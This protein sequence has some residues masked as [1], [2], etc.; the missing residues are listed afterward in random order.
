MSQ[1]DDGTGLPSGSLRQTLTDFAQ[2]LKSGVR[3]AF[4]RPLTRADFRFSADQLVLLAVL[5]LLL[6]L[7]VGVVSGGPD[8][9]IDWDAL[10]GSVFPLLLLLLAAYLVSKVY[11]RDAIAVE[12]PI[13][14]L[15]STPVFAA[16]FA[17]AWFLVLWVVVR[18]QRVSAPL[19]VQVAAAEAV[20]VLL[21]LAS[22]PAQDGDILDN[23]VLSFSV[24]GI[25]EEAVKALPALVL[26]ESWKSLG[27]YMMI[28]L[29]GLQ[30][31][32]KD[33]YEAAAVDGAGPIRR[34]WHVTVPMLRP[35]VAVV[36]VLAALDAMQVFTSVFV[37]TQSKESHRYPS[38]VSRTAGCY[39]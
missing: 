37:M 9:S 35:Y 7:A 36:V 30:S 8:G 11:R 10:P 17:V 31:I 26:V 22:F 38:L 33:L 6:N 4:W 13:V 15:A 25:P 29:A 2:N 20:L 27:Y 21:F 12:L 28:Y 32:P 16:Y 14:L 34:L 3:L 24:V 1:P 18:P 39:K 5:Q 19:L 23:L